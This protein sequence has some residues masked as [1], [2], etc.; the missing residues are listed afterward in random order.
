MDQ[1]FKQE[2]NPQKNKQKGNQLKPNNPKFAAHNKINLLRI[3]GENSKIHVF[4]YQI[5]KN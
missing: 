1:R 4:T 3:W 5:V 2:I